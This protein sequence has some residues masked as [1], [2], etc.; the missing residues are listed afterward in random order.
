MALGPQA[1]LLGV[2]GGV[3]LD[4]SGSSQSYIDA[5]SDAVQITGRVSGVVTNSYTKA[6]LVG[7]SD[8][9]AG[10]LLRCCQAVRCQRANKDAEQRCRLACC[11]ACAHQK[12]CLRSSKAQTRLSTAHHPAPTVLSLQGQCSVTASNAITTKP[13]NKV[14][15]LPAAPAPPRWTCGLFLTQPTDPGCPGTPSGNRRRVRCGRGG[16]RQGRGAAAG[17]CSVVCARD[18]AKL[19]GGAKRPSCL[20]YLPALIAPLPS[21]LLPTPLLLQSLTQTVIIS[22]PGTVVSTGGSTTAVA[23]ERVACSVGADQLVV[24]LK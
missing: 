5:A 14:A 8:T 24:R 3:T 16:L 21:S 2:T 22:G 17:F 4:V 12:R 13:C 20:P 10:S 1:W 11:A 19:G 6:S 23:F 15:R 9:K 18:A 7:S